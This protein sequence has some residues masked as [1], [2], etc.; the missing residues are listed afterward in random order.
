MFTDSRL[1]L[2]RIQGTFSFRSQVADSTCFGQ[3]NKS[4]HSL[5]CQII[6]I[7]IKAKTKIDG[8]K[9]RERYKDGKVADRSKITK[10]AVLL[11]N[12]NDEK[13]EQM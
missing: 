6:P 4:T 1:N 9:N 7:W 11:G 5:P 13:V 10:L 3:I 2:G 12:S 8:H